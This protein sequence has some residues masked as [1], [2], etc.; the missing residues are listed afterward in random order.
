MLTLKQR[1]FE[2][3]AAMLAAPTSSLTLRGNRIVVAGSEHRSVSLLEVA[4]EFDQSG[5]TRRFTASFDI[6]PEFAKAE[7]PEYA[8][9][10]ITGA[11]LVEVQVDMETGIVDARR[12][13]AAHDVGKAVNPQGAAGQIEGAIVM[14]MGAA[15][16]EEFLP[17]RTV[18]LSHYQVPVSISVPHIKV[19]LVEVPSRLGPYGVKGLGEAPLL[20]STP[21]IINA[22]SRAIGCR[23]RSI[24]ATP[25]RIVAAIHSSKA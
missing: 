19:V 10:F 12:V 14:G 13:V 23:I 1:V 22:V 2:V 15:L 9:L 8:P 3:A 20:P 21:A 18:D 17:G 24:P 7:R 4:R 16:Y 5:L 6:S 25:E 11:H